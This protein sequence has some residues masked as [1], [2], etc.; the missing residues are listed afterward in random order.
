MSARIEVRLDVM[1]SKRRMTSKALAERIGVSE[2][3]LSQIKTGKIKGMR[4][5]TLLALC[6]VLDCEPGDLL[7]LVRDED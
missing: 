2:V 4:F 3:A 6:E 1:L 5:S 7:V